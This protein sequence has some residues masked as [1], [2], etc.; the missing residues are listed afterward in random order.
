M[1]KCFA[2]L[3]VS[4]LLSFAFGFPAN[5]IASARDVRLTGSC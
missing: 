2:L 1:R 3:F 4:L 5:E